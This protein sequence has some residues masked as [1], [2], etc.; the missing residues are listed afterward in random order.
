MVAEREL[1]EIGAQMLDPTCLPWMTPEEVRA[2][3][4]QLELE[5][6]RNPSRTLVIID[7]YVVDLE[8]TDANHPMPIWRS[9]PGGQAILKAYLGRDATHAFHGGLNN[10]TLSA[11]QWMRHARV[12]RVQGAGSKDALDEGVYERMYKSVHKSAERRLTTD[13]GF[14][15][16]SN[17]PEE[18]KEE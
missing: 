4:T 10:H 5:D 16:R 14:V 11:V 1:E 6:V 17:S 13:S 18:E 9:H 2:A 3:C 15:S 7:G 8:W 12:A